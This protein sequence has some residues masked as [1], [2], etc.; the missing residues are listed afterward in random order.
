MQEEEKGEEEEEECSDPFGVVGGDA[1]RGRKVGRVEEE[2]GEGMGGER[3]VPPHDAVTYASVSLRAG[4]R[5]WGGGEEAG[6]DFLAGN[7]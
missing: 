4:E 6:V 3:G 7:Y 1:G 5:F 2:E